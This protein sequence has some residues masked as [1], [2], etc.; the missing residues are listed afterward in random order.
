MTNKV[1]WAVDTIL[2]ENRNSLANISESVR[3][4]DKAELFETKYIP[5][6]DEQKYPNINPIAVPVILYGSIGYVNKCKEPF[7][8]GVYA[9]DYRTDFQGYMTSPFE[10]YMLNQKFF[11]L[12]FGSILNQIEFIFETFG[13]Y[14]FIRPNSGKKSFAGTT[15]NAWNYELE[16]KTIKELQHVTDDEMC[17]LAPCQPILAEYRIIIGNRKVIGYSQYRRND[18]LDIRR[19]I[20]ESGLTFAKFIANLPYQPD[21]IYTLDIAEMSNA[22]GLYKIIELNTFNCSGLYAIDTDVLV[23]EV[24]DIVLKDFNGELDG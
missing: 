18:I 23:R 12:P 8:P 13:E 11:M 21:L 16:L 5:L 22:I 7:Y 24:T 20:P 15:F 3:N 14:I 17:V 19:D 9:F 6:S 1:L 2:T 10:P 4:C